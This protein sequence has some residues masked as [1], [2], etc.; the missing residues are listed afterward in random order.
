MTPQTLIFFGMQGSGK[1]TQVSLLK[2]HITAG[3]ESA[4]IFQYETGNGFREMAKTES[5]TASLV[6][7][8]L[9]EGGIIP[10]FL[11]IALWANAF[12]NEYKGT[13]HVVID[14]FPRRIVEAEVLH[15]ALEFYN[16]LPA[17]VIVLDLNE[18][19]AVERLVAR[20]RHDDTEEAI[21]KRLGWYKD[22]VSP[23]LDWY[24]EHDGYD[25]VKI[26]GVQ[27]E[28]EV[29]TDIVKAIS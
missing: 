7:Q 14:G 5:H 26:N 18:D 1:G 29:H 10:V 9:D 22:D 20:G 25:V 28:K 21:R 15:S 24:E 8:T 16:R 23:I 17:K 4:E 6:K 13:E 27:S 3:D 2:E 12:K 19:L 11:P